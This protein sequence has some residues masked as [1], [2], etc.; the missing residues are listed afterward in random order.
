MVSSF[1]ILFTDFGT[2]FVFGLGWFFTPSVNFYYLRGNLHWDD[3]KWPKNHFRVVKRWFWV[4]ECKFWGHISIEKCFR[5]FRSGTGSAIFRVRKIAFDAFFYAFY[6]I[7]CTLKMALP[8]PERK[9]RKHFSI[10]MWPQNL[11]ST[12]QNQCLA[13]RKWFFGHFKTSQC[14][15]PHKTQ[16]ITDGVKNHPRA[17]TKAVP[18]SVNK[19]EQLETM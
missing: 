14:K 11:H 17:K 10:E 6:A 3:L 2:V 4:V 5:F 8:V 13:T 9:K 12:P 16:K 1:S 15:F 19:M 7:F 18:K